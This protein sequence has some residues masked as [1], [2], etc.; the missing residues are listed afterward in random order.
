MPDIY[1]DNHH[2]SGSLTARALHV[3]RAPSLTFDRSLSESISSNFPLTN[4]NWPIPLTWQVEVNYRPDDWDEV[5]RSTK[6]HKYISKK[7]TI[8]IRVL[9]T[10]ITKLANLP[11]LKKIFVSGNCLFLIIFFLLA[12]SSTIYYRTIIKDLSNPYLVW[13][14]TSFINIPIPERLLSGNRMNHQKLRKPPI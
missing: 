12:Y 8:S 7:F 1:N 5:I 6:S 2:L 13:S 14:L 9:L 4:S 11:P 10:F 3:R